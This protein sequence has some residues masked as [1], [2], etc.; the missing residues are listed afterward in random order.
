MNILL[1]VGVGVGALLVGALVGYL[2]RLLVA[3]QSQ[4]SAEIQA[5][6]LVQQARQ[7][8]EEHLARARQ[9]ARTV[10]DR[11]RAELERS[12]RDQ[13]QELQNAEKRLRSKEESL[14]RKYEMIDRKEKELFDRENLLKLDQQK[15]EEDRKQL[16]HQQ[17]KQRQLLERISG[18]SQEEARRILLQ[19]LEEEVKAEFAV[20]L[21][22]F[23]EEYRETVD[24]RAR[25]TLVSAMQRVAA[26]VAVDNTT[27]IVTIPD[28]LKGRIIGREGRNIRTFEQL[29]GVDIIVDDT[30]ETLVISSFDPVKREIARI[31]MER[32]VQDS[33]IHP[34]RIEEVVNKVTA[35]FDEQVKK[36]GEDTA[37]GVGVVGLNPEI[38]K[39]LGRLKFRTSYGQ[40]QLQH[41]VEVALI[42][43]AI[44]AEVGADVAFCKRAGLLH[45]IGKAISHEVEG[46]HHELSADIAKKSGESEKML[47]AILSHHEGVAKPGSVEAFILAAADAI[48]ASRPGAR[49]DTV[50]Q[51]IKRVEKVE[52]VARSFRGVT[53]AY[54]IYAGRELRVMVEPREV[55]D[56][57]MVTLAHDMAKRIEKELEYP[58][59]IK[60][61]L[62]RETRVEDF[63]K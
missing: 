47:N 16:H 13:K 59:Q 56:Q 39:L 14:D 28:E 31:A 9:E 8:A 1:L 32:L 49:Q 22:K 7:E 18:L 42:A 11:E 63:A 4:Q 48:S 60:I 41:T 61:I 20:K 35:E 12:T 17:E 38:L 62:I 30:P 27:T 2:L 23:D 44:A 55:S 52:K 58:G 37:L 10:I 34:A 53:N 3:M 15:L 46:A 21:K 54:A 19:S 50:E 25:E 24:K 26:D 33:R 43:G 57:Q 45:D 36:I 51:Y 29:T 5:Q 40:N 6:K